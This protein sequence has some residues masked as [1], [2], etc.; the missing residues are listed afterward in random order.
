[1]DDLVKRA[2]EYLSHNAAESGA[3]ILIAE[4]A[5][6][7]EGLRDLCTANG[8]ASVTDVV[9]SAVHGRT[10]RELAWKHYKRG[11]QDTV[12]ALRAGIAGMSEDSVPK[13]DILKFCEYTEQQQ[14]QPLPPD[15]AAT[16]Q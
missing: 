10:S 12:D 7:I 4:M 13:S 5:D 9:V 15:F 8:Y 6:H 3:D 16:L 14:S 2:R 1:M 11:A